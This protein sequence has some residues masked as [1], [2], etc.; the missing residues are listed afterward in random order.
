[1]NNFFHL[2]NI[3]IGAGGFTL[4]GVVPGN[5]NDLVHVAIAVITG[6]I[7]IIHLIRSNKKKKENL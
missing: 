1:V 3:A 6:V 5:S 7:Q 2:K 4:L